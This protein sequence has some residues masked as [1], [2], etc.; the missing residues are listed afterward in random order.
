MKTSSIDEFLTRPVSAAPGFR[1]PFPFVWL[2]SL[3]LASNCFLAVKLWGGKWGAAAHEKGFV[4]AE[5][6]QV[7]PTNNPANAA[8]TAPSSVFE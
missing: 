1:V 6:P 7:A 5:V 4:A 2:C 3:L 8:T